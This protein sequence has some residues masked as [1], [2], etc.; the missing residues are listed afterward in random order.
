VHS[1]FFEAHTNHTQYNFK[2]NHHSAT[3]TY[4]KA[5]TMGRNPTSRA[6]TGASHDKQANATLETE[7]CIDTASLRS[8][9]LAC[10]AK[11][12]LTSVLAVQGS[13]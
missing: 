13:C 1:H 3:S 12:S 6:T 2:L 10:D 5:T 7:G 9:L 4:N 11:V 8:A